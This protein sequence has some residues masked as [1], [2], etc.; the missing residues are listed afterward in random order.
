MKKLYSVIESLAVIT[1]LILFSSKSF[2]TTLDITVQNF[3]FSPSSISAVVGDTIRWTRTG[4][5]HTT[6]CDGSVLTSRPSGAASWNANLN[7]STPVFKY[8]I[9]VAGTYNYKCAPHGAGGMVGVINA[10]P[11][12]IKLN[13]TA[14]IQ[15]FWN[16]AAMVNDTMKV[17][18]RNSVFPYAKIDSSKV[19]VNSSGNGLF[20]FNS[21]SGGNY[22]IVLNHRN[23]I[24]TWSF[25]AQTFTGGVTKVYD[26]TTSANQA[27][28]NN[29]VLNSGKFTIYSGDT[30]KDEIIDSGDLSNVENDIGVSGYVISDLSGD[31]FVDAFDLS[32]AE[33][34]VS[35]GVAISRP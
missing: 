15:G 34:N 35:N 16:G 24:E 8:V 17:Y 2:S 30:N 27:Y 33:N 11:A 32:I 3:S 21:A 1:F 12:L 9:T 13:L 4:G 25:S 22:Y 7:S 10:A 6:T 19:K 5:T 28:G 29:Q 26:F 18:L 14:I 23:S 20:T 31:D